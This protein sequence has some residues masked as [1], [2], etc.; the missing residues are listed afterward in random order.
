VS[1]FD[2][3]RRKIDLNDRK[4]PIDKARGSSRK[5]TEL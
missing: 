4:Y 5:Y 3:A 1:L 2:A